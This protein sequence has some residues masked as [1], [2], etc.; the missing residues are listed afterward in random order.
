MVTKRYHWVSNYTI[1]HIIFI[2]NPFH[3]FNNYLNLRP[4]SAS[5]VKDYSPRTSRRA[6]EGVRNPRPYPGNPGRLK[7]LIWK[8]IVTCR[9][10]VRKLGDSF[11]K[12]EHACGECVTNL[13]IRANIQVADRTAYRKGRR[14]ANFVRSEQK[15]VSWHESA[16]MVFIHDGSKYLVSK[17]VFSKSVCWCEDVND[18]F[19]PLLSP[20]RLFWDTRRK[21]THSWLHRSMKVIPYRWNELFF[22][23]PVLVF[24][25]HPS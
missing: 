20:E 3:K 19:N 22:R 23:I 21:K 6:L 5:K 7:K 24:S 18:L 15:C 13:E 10:E 4:E 1:V 2:K 9:W 17:L 16:E 12:L 14:N 11:R 8:S 25:Y